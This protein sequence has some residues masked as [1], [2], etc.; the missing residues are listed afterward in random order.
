MQYAEK[1]INNT[2]QFRVHSNSA[3]RVLYLIRVSVYVH[4]G[5]QSV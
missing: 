1:F 5:R 4:S 2:R 3:D